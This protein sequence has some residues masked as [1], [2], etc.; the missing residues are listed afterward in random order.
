[1]LFLFEIQLSCEHLETDSTGQ[2]GTFLPLGIDTDPTHGD[3][4]V[5]D[6]RNSCVIKFD[7]KLE[8]ITQWR[9]YNHYDQYDEARPKLI[10]VYGQKFYMIVEHS[11]K[12]Y[13]NQGLF[14]FE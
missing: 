9:V 6:Y 1:L 10:S 12:P 2:S 8:F 11:S 14:D 3:V 4:Y 7:D 13:Y 5:C